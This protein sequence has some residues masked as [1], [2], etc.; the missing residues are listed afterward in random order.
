VAAGILGGLLTP[1][2]LCTGS[3]AGFQIAVKWLRQGDNTVA[4]RTQQTA[5]ETGVFSL[6]DSETEIL[7]PEQSPVPI[8]TDV[9]EFGPGDELGEFTGIGKRT[10][11]NGSIYEGKFQYDKQNGQGKLTIPNGHVFEGNFQDGMLNEGKQITTDYIYEGKFQQFIPCGQGKL[12][13]AN[14]S[15]EEGQFEN[16]LLNGEGKITL[17]NGTIYKGQFQQ[18]RLNGQGILTM[19]DGS[20]YEGGFVGGQC[21]G[22]GCFKNSN[23]RIFQGNFH[24]GMPLGKGE[25]TDEHGVKQ[26]GVFY[27]HENTFGFRPVDTT[28][29]KTS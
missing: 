18:G 3:F 28:K 11:E 15:I 6:P 22:K 7:E 19:S 27:L 4:D 1:F 12:T 29:I 8:H 24:K 14:G 9:R 16:G 13:R 10:Y 17:T 21:Q 23:R 5:K 25:Y 20:S 26:K 2:L